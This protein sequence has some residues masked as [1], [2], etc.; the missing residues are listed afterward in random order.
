MS[1][2]GID[3]ENSEVAPTYKEFFHSYVYLFYFDE[4]PYLSLVQ[5]YGK[6]GQAHDVLIQYFKSKRGT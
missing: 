4:C 6:E 5:D 1:I 3:I 2:T